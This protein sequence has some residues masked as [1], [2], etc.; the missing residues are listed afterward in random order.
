MY[1]YEVKLGK[2]L[3]QI[4]LDQ[5]RNPSLLNCNGLNLRRLLF[6]AIS[7]ENKS[8]EVWLHEELISFSYLTNNL[9]I[10]S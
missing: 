6:S 4:G 8:I 10:A 5:P 7:A 3:F 9:S 1:F 2:I